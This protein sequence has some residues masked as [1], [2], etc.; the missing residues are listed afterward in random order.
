MCYRDILVSQ[1]TYFSPIPDGLVPCS[2]GAG[3]VVAVGKEVS[4]LKVGDRVAT[5]FFPHWLP[6]PRA[7]KW[8]AR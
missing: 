7:P 6:V 1:N 8:T 3:D 4:G 2:D 5:L